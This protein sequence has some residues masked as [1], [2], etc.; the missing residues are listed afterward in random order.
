[1]MLVTVLLVTAFQCYWI[2][3]LYREEYKDLQNKTAVLLKQA[4]QQQQAKRV[5]NV[6]ILSAGNNHHRT[7]RII[8]DSAIPGDLPLPLRADSLLK[9]E[10]KDTLLQRVFFS[11]PPPGEPSAKVHITG[12]YKM[13]APDS[14]DYT[15]E[16]MPGMDSNMRYRQIMYKLNRLFDSLPVSGIDSGFRAALKAERI[17]IPY[18][19]VALF[20]PARKKDSLI[21]TAALSTGL[22]VSGWEGTGGYIAL[23]SSP[24]GHI[25]QKLIIPLLVA[26]LITGITILSFAMLYRN[27]LAQQQLASIK[28]ELIS[29]ITHE[30]KTPIATVAVAIEALRNFDAAGNPQKNREYLDISA[31]ELQRLSLLTDKVLRLSMFEKDAVSFNPEQVNLQQLVTEVMQYMQLQ[32]EKAGAGVTFTGTAEPFVL[33]ADRLHLVSVVYNLLDNAVKYG[34]SQ[35]QIMVKL[36]REQDMYCLEIKDNG[37]G[38]PPVYHQKVFEKFFRVPGNDRHN[39]KGYGLGL[40]YVAHI[41][42]QHHGSIT[43]SSNENNGSTFTVKLPVAHEQH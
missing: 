1:M 2:T 12:M 16:P 33:M 11:G 24:A 30:L 13:P 29:N 41:V 4:V 23:F 10:E 27:L 9:N 34:G 7:I 39:V 5:R 17:N 43:V 40:S 19:L 26:V 21:T 3:R 38:I 42:Q 20:P 22:V 36:Y 25:M 6:L 14:P 32:F 15:V 18:R 28:N 31:M 8:R 37:I 35:P